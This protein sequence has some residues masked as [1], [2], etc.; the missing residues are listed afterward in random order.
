MAAV[1]AL[2]FLVAGA[3]TTIYGPLVPAL[4]SLF[5]LFDHQV[6]LFFTV[7][8][9]TS[10]AI[11]AVS[12]LVARRHGVGPTLGAGYGLV[13]LGAAALPGW[14]AWPGV[15]VASAFI[16]VGLGLVIPTTNIYFAQRFAARGSAAVTMLNLAWGLG[17]FAWPA[18]VRWALPEVRR[19]TLPLAAAALVTAVALW[20]GRA[21]L[22]TPGRAAP[23]GSPSAA[24]DAVDPEAVEAA[25]GSNSWIA[26]LFGLVLLAYGGVETALGGWL[27]DFVRRATPGE[28]TDWLLV[29]SAFYL[30]LAAG[31]VA[32][33]PI[34]T[35]ATERWLAL[36]GLTLATIV[37][38]AL[39]AGHIEPMTLAIA[40]GI[41][42]AAL[43]P[44]T[45]T[46]ATRALGS[47]ATTWMPPI[48][49][50]SGVG[51]AIV[52]WLVGVVASSS[53]SLASGLVVPL[54]ATL[55]ML[56]AYLWVGRR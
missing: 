16:G 32:V 1:A 9:G 26:V 55:F 52:P 47:R 45:V 33:L 15:L 35:R 20:A 12:G 13:A 56:G 11:G 24:R 48:V 50:M 6:G 42:L 37:Q 34:L 7:Q 18:L 3:A 54:M 4:R 30:A 17:A 8:S 39:V 27:G 36:G 46:V 31:R 40:S 28:G 14:W 21:Q 23:P 44:V 2:A 43:F 29:P 25:A 22:A 51:G 5:D 10:V 41:G 49:A 19:A 38:V 53:G